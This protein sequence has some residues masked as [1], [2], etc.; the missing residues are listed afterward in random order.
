MQHDVAWV[1]VIWH[2][3]AEG[4]H[5]LFR[6]RLDWDTI[7]ILFDFQRR[8]LLE[9]QFER[10]LVLNYMADIFIY[11]L[12]SFIVFVHRDSHVKSIGAYRLK[13]VLSLFAKVGVLVDLSP[14][15]LS[16]RPFLHKPGLCSLSLLIQSPFDSCSTS[17]LTWQGHSWWVDRW[18]GR[19]SAT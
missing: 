3:D 2:R 12:G 18:G 17:L 9:A 5:V 4:T 1:F 10:F 16:P 13:V 15:L 7:S 14:F 19:S 8:G 11:L 6:Q